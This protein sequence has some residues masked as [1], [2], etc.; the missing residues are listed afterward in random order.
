MTELCEMWMGMGTETGMGWGMPTA[1]STS[2]SRKRT[3]V[4]RAASGTWLSRTVMSE[5]AA[6]AGGA[7]RAPEQ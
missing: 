7:H 4:S 2:C 1:R 6:N 5:A 3:Q